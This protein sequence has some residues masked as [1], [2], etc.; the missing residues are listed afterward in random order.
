MTLEV[1]D[2]PHRHIEN[3]V[4]HGGSPVSADRVAELFPVHV[5]G[6]QERGQDFPPVGPLPDGIGA[7]DKSVETLVEREGQPER[8]LPVAAAVQ[9]L[10]G[11]LL[12]AHVGSPRYVRCMSVQGLSL[13]LASIMAAGDVAALDAVDPRLAHRAVVSLDRMGTLTSRALL[14]RYGVTVHAK[15]DPE[16]GLRVRGLTRATWDA[17]AAG[18]LS[19]HEDGHAAWF[20]M[21]GQEQARLARMLNRLPAGEREC[22]YLVGAAWAAAST[23]RKYPATADVSASRDLVRLP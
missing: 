20:G 19:A 11:V 21:A 15:P 5:R 16:V 2:V 8:H 22:L 6:E 13:L 9:T 18:M 10:A 4:S 12:L 14:D 17:V 7:S 3:G 23:A 1:Q